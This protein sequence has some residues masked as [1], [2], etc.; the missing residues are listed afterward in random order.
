MWGIFENILYFDIVETILWT[1]NKGYLLLEEHLSRLNNS[2]IYFDYPVDL[3][4]IN[5]ELN[6]LTKKNTS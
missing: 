6:S 3:K 1:P 4:K 2:A 5:K